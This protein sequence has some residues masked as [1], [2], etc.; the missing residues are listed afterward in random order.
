MEPTPAF[1]G[2]GTS[3]EQNQAGSDH[4]TEK[5]ARPLSPPMPAFVDIF[6]AHLL[7]A[8]DPF[9]QPQS[10]PFENDR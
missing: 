3:M 8:P 7:E 6:P 5:L 4:Q 2:S 10:I 9:G 1:D